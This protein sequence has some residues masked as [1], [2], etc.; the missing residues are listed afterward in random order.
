[1]KAPFSGPN[2]FPRPHLQI[3]SHWVLGFQGMNLG[4]HLPSLF[5]DFLSWLAP[6]TEKAKELF[7]H[8]YLLLQIVQLGEGHMRLYSHDIK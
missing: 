2:Y 1:M 3:S 5:L 4:G 6:R 7:S 8:A